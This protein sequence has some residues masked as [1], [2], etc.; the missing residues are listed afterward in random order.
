[1][2]LRWIPWVLAFFL[3]SGCQQEDLGSQEKELALEARGYYLSLNRASALSQITADYGQR[4]YDFSL[5][6]QLEKDRCQLTLTAPEN[7]A[8]IQVQQ[9][10]IGQDSKLLWEDLI[11]ETGN[12]SPQGLSPITA[13]PTLIQSLK[14][15]YVE[16]ARL[17]NPAQ[18]S[19]GLVLEIFC[20]DPQQSQ[21]Q[22]LETLLWLQ[23]ETFALLGGELYQDGRLV[24]TC[25]VSEFQGA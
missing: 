6:F 3:L 19:S 23:P 1:M 25:L 17:H 22:G 18:L 5:V 14:N 7:L 2:N 10:F 16:S 11:L 20:R 9:E 12:L 15:G 13:L 4:I 8:G 21:G 24:I